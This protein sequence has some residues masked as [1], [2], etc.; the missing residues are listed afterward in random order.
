[1]NIAIRPIAES[2][3]Y[4]RYV[5]GRLSAREL[6]STPE[7]HI[8]C[9]PTSA[10]FIEDDASYTG[11][12]MVASPE[13]SMS[14]SVQYTLATAALLG[15]DYG[16]LVPRFSFSY[17]DDVFYDVAEGRGV[18]DKKARELIDVGLY[19]AKE[20]QEAGLIDAVQFLRA[21]AHPDGEHQEGHQD[22]KG[23]QFIAQGGEDPELPDD[24]DHGNHD[25]HYS[26]TQAAGVEIK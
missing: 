15:G 16:E 21:V 1:M 4:L 9:N 25:H 8:R 20:A 17:R 26:G 13:W 24:R 19:G 11:N 6:L 12:R 22:G 10:Q 23:I 5:T 18:S 2:D 7:R 14:G 3:L